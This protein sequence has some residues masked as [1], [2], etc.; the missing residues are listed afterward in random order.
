[1]AGRPE[2]CPS[3]GG[4]VQRR[5]EDEVELNSQA[6]ELDYLIGKVTRFCHAGT[7]YQ[8]HGQG[9]GGGRRFL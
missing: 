8:Q 1:M 9:R 2:N 3:D 6:M 5:P 7:T 4:T